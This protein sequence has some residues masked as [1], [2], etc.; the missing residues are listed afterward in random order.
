[1]GSLCTKSRKEEPLLANKYQAAE[2]STKA[3]AVK[4]YS[5]TKNSEISFTSGQLL[6]I[7]DKTQKGY[8]MGQVEGE[9]PFGWFPSASVVLIT[10][11]EAIFEME[12][13]R[14]A[15]SQ[16]KKADFPIQNV[17][18]KPTTVNAAGKVIRARANKSYTPSSTRSEVI[19]G[20]EAN[21]ISFK[22]GDIIAITDKSRADVWLGH[23]EG[24]SQ[25]G[26]FPAN[27]VEVI[28]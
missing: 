22:A 16:N 15:A 5:A 19:D 28:T 10:E 9:G 3:K 11:K 20:S 1:M 27:Y 26:W 8:W 7:A 23:V 25:W 12:K 4:D 24:S 2:D 21:S 17:E 18:R 14:L 6:D 13:R